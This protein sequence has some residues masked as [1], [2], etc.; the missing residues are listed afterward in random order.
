MD[1]LPLSPPLRT[2][3]REHFE[4]R[5]YVFK[6][7]AHPSRLMIIDELDL[8]IEPDKFWEAEH[9]HSF[10]CTRFV[11]NEILDK[12]KNP[13]LLAMDDVEKIFDDAL[14]CDSYGTTK[15]QGVTLKRAR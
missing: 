7:L 5:S 1:P 8:K 13:I 11:E 10:G 3:S 12:T 15:L 14:R 4:E 9:S 6:A 2:A